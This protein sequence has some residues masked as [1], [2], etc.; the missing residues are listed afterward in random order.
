MSDSNIYMAIEQS[1]CF[2]MRERRE[3]TGGRTRKGWRQAE[4]DGGSL[5]LQTEGGEYARPSVLFSTSGLDGALRPVHLQEECDTNKQTNFIKRS[6]TA[7]VMRF[8]QASY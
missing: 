7:S 1:V 2:P 8:L 3:G 6:S 5:Q 4:T